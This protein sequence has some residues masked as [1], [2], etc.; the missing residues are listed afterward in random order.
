MSLVDLTQPFDEDTPIYP[1]D[2]EVVLE[3]HAKY[4][5][6]GYSVSALHLGSHSGTHVDAP[7]HVIPDGKQ[8][9]EFAP[10]RFRF[11]ALLVDARS[12]AARSP[13]LPSL[14][15]DSPDSN[16]DLYVFRTDWS[17]HRGSDRYFLHPYLT[18][19]TARKCAEREVS[20][21]LDVLTPDPI[22]SAYLPEDTNGQG[23]IEDIRK[24]YG[25]PAHKILLGNE[26]FILENL[27]NLDSVPERFRLHAYP[28]YLESDGSPVRAVAEVGG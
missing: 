14:L 13:I 5:E 25:V 2:P 26:L 21:A 23:G 19:E 15:P 24:D 20:L 4:E 7:S 17:E 3:S 12:V 8:L 9:S 10:D 11:D 22:P 16:V 1:G 28:L 27:E 6:D 18:P